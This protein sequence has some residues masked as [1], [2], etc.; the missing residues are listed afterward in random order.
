MVMGGYGGYGW[1]LSMTMDSYGWIWVV[2]IAIH[3][4]GWKLIAVEFVDALQ[5]VKILVRFKI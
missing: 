4:Y 5:K 2:R 1:Q 3:P